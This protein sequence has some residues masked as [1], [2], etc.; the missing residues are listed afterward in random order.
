[1]L[2]EPTGGAHVNNRMC[3]SAKLML[4]ATAAVAGGAPHLLDSG[5]YTGLASIAR[6]TAPQQLASGIWIYRPAQDVKIL[7][8]TP[9][10]DSGTNDQT[11][12]FDINLYSRIPDGSGTVYAVG[13]RH[14]CTL[15]LGTTTNGSMTVEPFTGSSLGGTKTLRHYD[16]CVWSYRDTGDLQV[17]DKGFDVANGSGRIFVDMSC[18]D[19]IVVALQTKPAASA[20]DLVGLNEECS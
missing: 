13:Q 2:N 20:R 7:C 17:Y 8:L 5:T 9:L 1:M 11:A 3:A 6:G 14:R 4:N 18:W 16:T 10:S 15:T 12:V 19:T